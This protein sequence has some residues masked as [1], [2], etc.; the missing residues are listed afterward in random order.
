MPIKFYSNLHLHL[1]FC[2]R[3]LFEYFKFTIYFWWATWCLYSLSTNPHKGL[4]PYSIKKVLKLQLVLILIFFTTFFFKSQ[5]NTEKNQNKYLTLQLKAVNW[6]Y[7]WKLLSFWI[8]S[9]QSKYVWNY[10]FLQ[11]KAVN[12]LNIFWSKEVYLKIPFFTVESC[13]YSEYF[14][15][16]ATN[17]KTLFFTA[18]SRRVVVVLM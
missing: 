5:H 12:I 16:K 8:F 10:H 18:G 4:C 11:L 9:G 3:P 14:L 17:L 7:S 6:H 13:Y 15:V 1:S 2:Q